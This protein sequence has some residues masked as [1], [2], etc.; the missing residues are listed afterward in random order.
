MFPVIIHS[1]Q[2]HSFSSFFIGDIGLMGAPAK[3][4]GKAVE[5][6]RIFLGG[7]IG[8]N[9]KLATEFE[10]SIPVEDAVPVL[11][12]ILVDHFGAVTK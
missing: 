7:E 10:K 12:R 9:P 4:D 11:S 5:G 8:E 2:I 6:V 1:W 3:K